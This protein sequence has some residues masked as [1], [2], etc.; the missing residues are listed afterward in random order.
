MFVVSFVVGEGVGKCVVVRGWKGEFGYWCG[1]LS[2]GGYLF[3]LWREWRK[4][5]SVVLEFSE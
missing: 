2:L 3:Y 5:R 1:C 4:W